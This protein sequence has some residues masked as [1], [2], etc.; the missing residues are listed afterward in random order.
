MP[1]TNLVRQTNTP[2]APVPPYH[3]QH[4][5]LSVTCPIKERP[6]SPF[7]RIEDKQCRQVTGTTMY[8]NSP[9]S[10]YGIPIPGFSRNRGWQLVNGGRVVTRQLHSYTPWTVE[11]PRFPHRVAS[12]DRNC[13]NIILKIEYGDNSINNNAPLRY[14]ASEQISSTTTPVHAISDAI[15]I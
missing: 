7:I 9:G 13:A 11:L 15:K 4:S 5:T 2:Q 14:S 3:I 8:V 12:H 6:Y 10:S 1:P